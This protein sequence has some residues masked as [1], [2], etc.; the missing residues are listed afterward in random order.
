MLETSLFS[1]VPSDFVS[2]ICEPEVKSQPSPIVAIAQ[3]TGLASSAGLKRSECVW[4]PHCDVGHWGWGQ[5][6][7]SGLPAPCLPDVLP[8]THQFHRLSGLR[9]L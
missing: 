9:G 4:E 3:V 2:I 5:N 6:A 7:V 1:E 8:M